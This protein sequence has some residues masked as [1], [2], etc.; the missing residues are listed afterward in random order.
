MLAMQKYRFLIGS[1][2][3]FS[4]FPGIV[5][6]YME[7]QNLHYS[8]FLYYFEDN[9]GGLPKI[10]KDCP[11]IGPMRSR[12]S[13]AG[14]LFY[15]SNIEENTACTE[16]EILSVVPKIHRRYG[17]SDSYIIFQDVDFFS[18]K[19]P[20]VMQAPGNAPHCIKGSSITLFRN[21]IFPR[22]TSIDLHIVFYNGVNT[23]D[24]TP[25]FEAMK[26]MLPGI[27]YMSGV[28]YC[29]TE[30]EQAF[31]DKL[32]QRAIPLVSAACKFFDRLPPE[33]DA[34]GRVD[35]PKISVAPVLKKLCKQFGYSYIKH[36]YGL[37][38]IQKRTKNGHTISLGIDVG[39][40]FRAMSFYVD[41]VGVGFKHSIGST[42]RD[43]Y[44]QADAEDFLLRCFQVLSLAEKEVFPALD[45]HYPPTP[46]WFD[47]IM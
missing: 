27:R 1:K 10:M 22:W 38:F 4:D 26:K 45:A 8:R 33:R 40:C 47:P 13:N 23:Y 46:D 7:Q 11:N 21:S 18:Q 36:D 25:Y 44:D 28:E 37:F 16:E 31:Y 35:I 32:N 41:Y 19:I 6:N 17:L 14:E 5:Q 2:I 39:P 15:L 3:P 9:F 43:P 42:A 29:L 24:P 20:A 34:V 12:P 30:D